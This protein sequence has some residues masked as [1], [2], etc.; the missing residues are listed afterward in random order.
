MRGLGAG[1]PTPILGCGFLILKNKKM[2]K[3][4]GRG[5]GNQVRRREGAY[6]CAN[7]FYNYMSLTLT[8]IS[9]KL[10]KWEANELSHHS[11]QLL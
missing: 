9:H 10:E 3:G 5:E 6:E 1:L 2:G 4:K 11:H 7:T 8:K